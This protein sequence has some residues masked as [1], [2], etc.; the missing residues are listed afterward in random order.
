[1]QIRF[2]RLA[3]VFPVRDVARALRHYRQLGFVA[4][5]YEEEDD[6]GPIYGFLRRGNIDLHLARVAE[7]DPDKNTS[8]CYLYVDDADALYAE[9]SRAGVGGR[10]NA[11][12]DTPYRLRELAHVDPD[13][14]LLRVGSPLAR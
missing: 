7:L 4:E 11:P 10:L 13:G 1:M 12:V 3:P 8:A 6:D 5:A 14:N 9:W 2:E